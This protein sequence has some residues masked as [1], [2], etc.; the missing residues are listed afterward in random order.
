VGKKVI[1]C[2]FFAGLLLFGI[3]INVRWAISSTSYNVSSFGIIHYSSNP[4]L[5]VDGKQIVDSLGNPVFL[6]GCAKMGL[7]YAHPILNPGNRETQPEY[8][9]YD[10]EVIAGWGAKLIRVNF[11]ADWYLENTENYRD[12]VRQWVEACTSR[13]MNVIMDCHVLAKGVG[14]IRPDTAEDE[15]DIIVKPMI[16]ALEQATTDY[17]GNNRVIGVEINEPWLMDEHPDEQHIWMMKMY[18]TLAQRIHAINPD[19]LVFIDIANLSWV[20]DAVL[21]EGKQYLTE[22]NLVM[23]PHIYEAERGFPYQGKYY[24]DDGGDFWNYYEQGD[25]AE[26]KS[27]FYQFL[28]SYYKQPFDL[29]GLPVV[30]TEFAGKRTLTQPLKDLMAYMNSH[31]YGYSYWT[32][33]GGTGSYLL[34]ADWQTLSP[35]GSVFVEGPYLQ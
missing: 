21:E 18:N 35:T 6:H 30:A 13:G 33:Y 19:L 7:E 32:Y 20:S 26:G 15:A 9:D 11:A 4:L 24:P 8:Y 34:E 1:F 31:G 29:Y 27:R 2:A 22:P 3:F 28:D 17:I 16:Q 23:A 10:A 25:N 14:L 5:R 12:Y